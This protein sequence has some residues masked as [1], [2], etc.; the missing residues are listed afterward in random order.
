MWYCGSVIAVAHASDERGRRWSFERLTM[1]HPRAIRQGM[2]GVD[3]ASLDGQPERSRADAQDASG[4]VQ[5]H[6]PFSG[7]SIAIVPSDVVVAAER[8][9]PFS[10]PAIST[11]SEEPI[12]IQDVR[13]EIVRT[14]PRQYTHGIDD[15]LRCVRGTFARVVVA[16]PAV[17]CGRRLSSE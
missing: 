8:D 6:P 4:F 15:V 11:P 5:I 12:P 9:H 2:S 3:F 13:H 1:K 10:S 14:N 7:P 16:A 17:R